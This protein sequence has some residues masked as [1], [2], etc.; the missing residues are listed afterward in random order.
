MGGKTDSTASCEDMVLN[1]EL[2]EETTNFEGWDLVLLRDKL[3]LRT[4][5]YCLNLPLSHNCDPDKG[6]A[7]WDS[8]SKILKLTL[9]LVR[10]FD[11]VN[12]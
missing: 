1:I 4:P 7:H 5:T 8:D 6:K 3:E 10:E 12:F 11:Y 9:R 2:P